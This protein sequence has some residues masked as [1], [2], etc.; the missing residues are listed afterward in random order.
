MATKLSDL[1]PRA[2]HRKQ[3]VALIRLQL[4]FTAE[5]HRIYREFYDWLVE[6]VTSTADSEGMVNEP[7]LITAI[8]TVEG[9]WLQT[10]RR[11]VRLFERA[12]IEAASI[13]FGSL[14]VMHNHYFR[15]F[16]ESLQENLTAEQVGSLINMW[17]HRRQRALDVASQRIYGDGFNLSSRVWRLEN[18]GVNQIRHTLSLAL[19]ERTSAV[20]LAQQLEPL[21]GAGQNCPRWAYKRLYGMTPSERAVD[22]TGLLQEGDCTS[23]GLAYAALRMARNEIQIAH[24]RMTDDIFRHAPWVEGEKIRLSPQ[25]P[26]PDLCDDYANGGPYQPGE[27][28]LPLHVQ[29]M[30]YKEAAVMKAEQFR[31]QVRDW[32]QGEN[33]FLGDYGEWLGTPNPVQLLPWALVIAASLALWLDMSADGHAA[34]LGVEGE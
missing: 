26:K 14:V 20:R 21:L 22:K 13:P 9:R 27:V 25:H 23:S 10:H 3:Q 18:D 12:R 7:A 24:H 17:E 29:C 11:W 6:S 16:E 33:D 8:P 30:C 31:Q 5:T 19:T 2:V 32:L 1:H 4:R 15:S 34:A 28:L